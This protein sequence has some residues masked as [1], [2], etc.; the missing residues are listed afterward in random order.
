MLRF[1]VV[2]DRFDAVFDHFRRYFRSFSV[3]VWLKF[4]FDL[5]SIWGSFRDLLGI[6]NAIDSIETSKCHKSLQCCFDFVVYFLI[7]KSMLLFENE[8]H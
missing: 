6:E 1:G 7:Q 8:K 3:R 4:V 5:F 2:F